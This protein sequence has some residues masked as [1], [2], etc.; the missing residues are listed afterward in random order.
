MTHNDIPEDYEPPAQE[1]PCLLLKK[2]K[3]SKEMEE[4]V[5]EED[6]MLIFCIDISG[7]MDCVFGGKSRL[8]SVKEA[9]GDEIKRL[10]F[11]KSKIKVGL[12]TF[13][14]EVHLIGDA[15]NFK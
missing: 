1:N 7:S 3:E 8:N 14:S 4:E 13:G 5:A 6:K 11:E 10:K 2:G 15:K 12:I 9:I